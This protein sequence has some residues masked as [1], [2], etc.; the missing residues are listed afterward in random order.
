MEKTKAKK[1]IV[2]S[3]LVLKLDTIL[4]PPPPSKCDDISFDI[5]TQLI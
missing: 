1:G 2:D 5:F 3:S 4:K